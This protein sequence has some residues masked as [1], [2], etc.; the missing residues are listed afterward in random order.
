MIHPGYPPVL[1]LSPF[2]ACSPNSGYNHRHLKLY[3]ISVVF[4]AN[5]REVI[6]LYGCVVF[7]DLFLISYNL[8]K[9][10]DGD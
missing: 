6:C 5:L 8:S 1:W 3:W 4:G 2:L 10:T 7:L 9:N